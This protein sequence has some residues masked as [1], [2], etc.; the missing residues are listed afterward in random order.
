MCPNILASNKGMSVTWWLS[1]IKYSQHSSPM[2]QEKRLTVK[3]SLEIGHLNLYQFTVGWWGHPTSSVSYHFVCHGLLTWS[4]MNKWDRVSLCD[5]Q[6]HSESIW[7]SPRYWDVQSL[8]RAV[9][10]LFRLLLVMALHGLCWCIAYL[11]DKFCQRSAW[12]NLY[13]T[14]RPSDSISPRGILIPRLWLWLLTGWI[15]FEVVG[16]MRFLAFAHAEGRMMIE[17]FQAMWAGSHHTFSHW[18]IVTDCHLA[19]FRWGWDK[20]MRLESVWE[21]VSGSLDGVNFRGRVPP[22]EMW[23]TQLMQDWHASSSNVSSLLLEMDGPSWGEI[24]W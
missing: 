14:A 7:D 1:L 8:M 12:C 18:A 2:A 23:H 4:W 21:A 11:M 19:L 9:L 16:V 22:R 17:M 3:W 13:C 6:L 20:R 10:T 24:F 15:N 5:C